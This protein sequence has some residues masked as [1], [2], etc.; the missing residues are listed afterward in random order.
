MLRI[1]LG[2]HELRNR[3]EQVRQLLR[4]LSKRPGGPAWST[5]R[6]TAEF[7]VGTHEGSP[8]QSS[9]QD[10]RFSVFIPNFRAMYFERWLRSQEDHREFWYLNRAYLDI[11]QI[12]G[13]TQEN[14][15]LC[16]HCDPNEPD[17]AS[18]VLYKRGP[19]LHI[20]AASYPISS[21]HIALNAGFVAE[22]LSSTDS[23]TEAMRIALVM[24][25]EEVLDA[26]R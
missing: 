7:I 9:H 4:P 15:F 11:Y 14:K 20:N 17:G 24:L 2:V 23:L 12:V 22:I 25:K 5:K 10:W 19:H 16:L 13:P 18:H 1:Q 6:G 3:G 26:L 21:A 8:L